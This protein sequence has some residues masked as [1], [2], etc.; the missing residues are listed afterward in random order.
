MQ[1]DHRG[2]F[3]R[4]DQGRDVGAHA[5]EGIA[6]AL[7]RLVLVVAGDEVVADVADGEA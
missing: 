2:T 4:A 1:R 7:P 6:A 5:C 3:A